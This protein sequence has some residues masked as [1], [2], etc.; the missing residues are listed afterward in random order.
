[1]L[2]RNAGVGGAPISVAGR[3]FRWLLGHR[4]NDHPAFCRSGL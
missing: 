2:F 3:K 4:L 1:M